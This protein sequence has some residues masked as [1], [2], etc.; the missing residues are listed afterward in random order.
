MV[1]VTVVPAL[2]LSAV[3]I[4]INVVERR[5]ETALRLEDTAYAFGHSLETA[6]DYHLRGIE[7]MAR[8]A[9][10]TGLD[11]TA[12]TNDLTAEQVRLYPDL[13]SAILVDRRGDI[14]ALSASQRINVG[15]ED[16]D[17]V[18]GSSVADRNYFR[19]PMATGAPYVS[20]V[21]QGRGLGERLIVALSAPIFNAGGDADGVAEAT[22]DLTRIGTLTD[23][24]RLDERTLVLLLDRQGQLIFANRD[25]VDLPLGAHVDGE[26]ADGVGPSSVFDKAPSRTLSVLF[27]LQQNGNTQRYLGTRF[28]LDNGWFVVAA[29][30]S[31]TLLASMQS[32]IVF[33]A[34]LLLVA[35]LLALIIARGLWKRLAQPLES[36][37]ERLRHFDPDHPEHL[38]Q[39]EL[40]SAP[41]E[42][43]VVM[44]S[45]FELVERLRSSL[46]SLAESRDNE[47]RLRRHLENTVSDREREIRL[48]TRELE[49]RS[50]QLKRAAEEADTAMRAKSDFLANMSH[51]MRTPLTAVLGFAETALEREQD[52]D[53]PNNEMLEAVLQNARHLEYLIND[54]LD[55]SRIEAGQMHLEQQ[56][57]DLAELFAGMR[58][59]E[60][61]RARDK[62]LRFALELQ[63]AIPQRILADEGRLLQVLLNL[64]SNAIKFTEQGEVR[65]ALA[66]LDDNHQLVIVVSDTGIGISAQQQKKLFERFSQADSSVTR[67]YGGTGL[68]LAISR[69]L[70]EL[71]G[72]SISVESRAGEGSSF[73]VVLPIERVDEAMLESTAALPKG[74]KPTRPVSIEPNS[75]SGRVL[76]AEDNNFTR[77]LIQLLLKRMGAEVTMVENGQL[78]VDAVKEQAFDLV[79]MDMH[80][81]VMGGLEATGKIRQS[82]PDV[83]IVAI[84]A[85]TLARHIEEQFAAGC[86]ETLTKPIDRAQFQ[87]VVS[88]YLPRGHSSLDQTSS[89][90]TNT[91]EM[92]SMDLVHPMADNELPAPTAE[93]D[94]ATLVPDDDDE[95]A[96]AEAKLRRGF[97]DSLSD[98]LLPLD[99]ALATNDRDRVGEILHSLKGT[100]GSYGFRR[101]SKLAF[102]ADH[103]WKERPGSMTAKQ[104][105]EALQEAALSLQEQAMNQASA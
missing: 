56:P 103:A 72:G 48:R 28:L 21:F 2:V 7:S 36:L 90:S 97:V 34:L 102:E 54:V 14:V 104:A 38:N 40:A 27:N 43:D 61:K 66:W 30:P 47:R 71:M 31:P 17:A 8:A 73:S 19:V 76:V 67:K 12:L 5:E 105:L 74:P 84:T 79:L 9:G 89:A 78:A 51:E 82:H 98:Y 37:A 69:Q 86:N 45:F 85:D 70:V 93:D 62:G 65:I 60:G 20:D 68:G 88:H 44:G 99:Y 11:D 100:A 29:S 92:A 49:K 101:L 4:P 95:L 83:P 1:L 32:Q 39:A 46:Q 77:E 55:L 58:A 41:E 26:R 15:Q 63:T 33:P 42:V 6:M 59:S 91:S 75:L 16:I 64:T 53:G 52:Q 81:P 80:M 10:I 96:A 57:V 94:L 23:T 50:E 35:M 87:K 25:D 3:L 22:L 13:L 24:A 18:V